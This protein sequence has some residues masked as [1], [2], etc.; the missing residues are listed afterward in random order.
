MNTPG[1]KATPQP[2]EEGCQFNFV[3]LAGFFHFS[4]SKFSEYNLC[5]AHLSALA[6]Y[7]PGAQQGIPFLQSE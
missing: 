1:N 6:S 5:S 2:Q 3:F 4:F 7:I